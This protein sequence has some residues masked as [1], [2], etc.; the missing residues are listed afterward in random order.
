MVFVA[1]AHYKTTHR[2]HQPYVLHL[3]FP[4][5]LLAC[6]FVVS[7][8]A[9]NSSDIGCSTTCSPT[10]FFFR[11][12]PFTS[13]LTLFFSTH[14]S[15]FYFSSFSSFARFWSLNQYQNIARPITQWITQSL[16]SPTNTYTRSLVFIIYSSPHT[17]LSFPSMIAFVS[18]LNC[19]HTHA[20]NW[21]VSLSI[22]RI[23]FNASCPPIVLSNCLPRTPVSPH[24]P[25]SSSPLNC[26]LLVSQL[27][28]QASPF[29]CA[30]NRS[31]SLLLCFFV[32]DS[33]V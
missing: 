20:E 22:A 10:L 19:F 25:F 32:F 33:L 1:C 7:Q 3:S 21:S 5:W 26:S 15:Q 9:P 12:L 18:S 14:S 23:H 24:L 11:L 13:F 30:I 4:W 17:C 31:Q 29:A 8:L 2:L 16:T 28:S 6:F 27:A